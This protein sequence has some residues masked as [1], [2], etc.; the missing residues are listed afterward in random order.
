MSSNASLEINMKDIVDKLP[1]WA[2]TAMQAG[3]LPGPQM[4]EGSIVDVIY[5]VEV[6]MERIK[7]NKITT[8]D[9]WHNYCTLT[10]AA[11]HNWSGGVG[12]GGA[13]GV[14][15]VSPSTDSS[16]NSPGQWIAELAASG[17]N[18]DGGRGNGGD[19]T[20]SYGATHGGGSR[21]DKRKEFALVS[22][23]NINIQIF[24]GNALNINPYLPFN[25]AIRRLI[26]AQGVDGEELLYIL[27]KVEKMGGHLLTSY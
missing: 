9:P 7:T 25:N 24:T 17:T 23:R 6:E 27:D 11:T 12:F 3:Q 5:M 22:P 26:F 19:P 4:V 18:G 20:G 10:P 8:T 16:V 15:G 13:G 14:N 1:Q 2:H 21:D